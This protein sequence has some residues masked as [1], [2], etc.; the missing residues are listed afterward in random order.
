MNHAQTENEKRAATARL[1]RALAVWHSSRIASEQP[2][3]LPEAR[4]AVA[5]NEAIEKGVIQP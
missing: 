2:I 5:V 3:S 4:L 1:F